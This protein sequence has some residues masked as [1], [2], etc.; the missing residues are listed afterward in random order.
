MG[1]VERRAAGLDCLEAAVSDY[2]CFEI[3]VPAY[4]LAAMRDLHTRLADT[5]TTGM[6]ADTLTELQFLDQTS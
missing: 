4:Q 1:V 2:S 5:D 3:Q 6:V